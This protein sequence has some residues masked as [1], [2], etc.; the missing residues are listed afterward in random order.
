M[1][2]QELDRLTGTLI[3]CGLAYLALIGWLFYEVTR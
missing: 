2:E 1:P 3:L